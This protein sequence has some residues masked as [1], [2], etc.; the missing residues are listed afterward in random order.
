MD[1]LTFISEIVKAAAWPIAA[2]V[3]ALFFGQSYGA[4]LDALK[5]EK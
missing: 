1:A 3:I 5:R 2:T 4:Y